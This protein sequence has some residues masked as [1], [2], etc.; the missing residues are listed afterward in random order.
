MA[1]PSPTQQITN[2]ISNLQS[3]VGDLQGSV[4]LTKARDAVEDFQ[5][6]VNGLAQRIVILRTRGYA[7]EKDMENQAQAF[8]QSWALLYPNLQSQI[9]VQSSALV[10][11][12]RPIEMQMPRLTAAASNPAAARGLLG[13]MQS[14][15][16]MLEVKVS[17]TEKTIEGMYD[18]FN[19]QVY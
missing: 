17:A 13:S 16:N 14:A 11:S 19:N 7:F 10:N 9:N 6:T 4:R 12:L 1:T 5:T 2:D 18:Q 15:V 3:K 8:V